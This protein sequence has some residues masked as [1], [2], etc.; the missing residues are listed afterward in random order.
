MR[1]WPGQDPRRRRCRQA[2]AAP[3]KERLAPRRVAGRHFW[4]AIAERTH[5]RHQ[6][7]HLVRA[8]LPRPRHPAVVDPGGD[9]RGERGVVGGATQDRAL[10]RRPYASRPLDPVT[11][12][13]LGV[14]ERTPPGE[15]GA[16]G[17]RACCARAT[18]GPASVRAQARASGVARRARVR[19]IVN[20]R[21]VAS[22]RPAGALH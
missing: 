20:L 12:R 8:Q 10:E 6:H 19:G 21:C 9:E 14:E 16:T 3:A 4:R 18:A 13:A 1:P 7:R 11:A 22:W 15:C 2:A 17:R 5:V